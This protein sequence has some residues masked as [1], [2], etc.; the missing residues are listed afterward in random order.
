MAPGESRTFAKAWVTSGVAW[1][2]QG[3][4]DGLDGGRWVPPGKLRGRT[5][6]VLQQLAGVPWGANS[7]M[8]RRPESR[9]FSSPLLK[10]KPQGPLG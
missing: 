8:I 4:K 1:A 2:L 9:G 6:L 7:I 5:T 10:L 3:P